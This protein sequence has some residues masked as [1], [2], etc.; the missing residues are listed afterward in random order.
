MGGG[1]CVGRYAP[2]IDIERRA[3]LIA[4]YRVGVEEVDAALAGADETR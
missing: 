1:R 2:I 3:E 4:R